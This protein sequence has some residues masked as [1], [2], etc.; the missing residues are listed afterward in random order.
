[1][2]EPP[3]ASSTVIA[4][5]RRPFHG[6]RRSAG[7]LFGVEEKEL[8]KT[9]VVDSTRKIFESRPGSTGSSGNG[10]SRLLIKS[11]STSSL[12]GGRNPSSSPVRRT[13]RQQSTDQPTKKQKDLLLSQ[14][15][16]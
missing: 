4:S 6:R 13:L 7:L 5:L 12:Y 10:S 3:E 15:V 11:R 2:T 9:G 16:L 8:P 1:M 14:Y